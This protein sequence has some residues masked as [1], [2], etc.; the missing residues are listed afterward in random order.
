MADFYTKMAATA[1]KLLT[2]FG[3]TVA[4]VRET[5]ALL[6]PITGAETSGV[7]ASTTTTGLLV[8]YPDKMIDGTRI[9]DSD[10]M[11]IA[12]GE[13]VILPTDKPTIGGEN[14]AIISIKT[15]KPTTVAVVYF[16]QVRR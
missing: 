16:V 12:S 8:P 6:D 3:A 14:W 2:K 1:L 9:L 13:T 10:R 15:I 4:L 5:G 7:D 11:L